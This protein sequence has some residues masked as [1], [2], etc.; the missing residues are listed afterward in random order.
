[1]NKFNYLNEMLVQMARVG[2]GVNSP[3]AM[4]SA[5]ATLLAVIAAVIGIEEIRSLIFRPKIRPNEL[6]LVRTVHSRKNKNSLTYHRLIVKNIWRW[7][8]GSAK[9]VRV[10]LSYDRDGKP[11]STD[12][13]PIP[14]RW[15]YWNRAKRD[16][17]RGEPAYLD[18]FEEKQGNI[19]KQY[20]FCW[21][22]DMA[23]SGSAE[24]NLKIFNPHSGNIRLQFYE[25][26]GGPVG[27][28][29]LKYDKG[30]D[31]FEVIDW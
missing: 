1:M 28:M 24:D 19:G 6:K 12:F 13:I 9:D 20:E 2:D 31:Y 4:F 26:N 25:R 30:N 5:L 15:T 23:G 29:T 3:W 21:A 11:P 7:L 18:V 22:D 17:S 10:F 27:D 14:L 16:I 8:G